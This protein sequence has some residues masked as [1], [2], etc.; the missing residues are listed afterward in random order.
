MPNAVTERKMV[1]NRPKSF[2]AKA[3]FHGPKRVL[4]TLMVIRVAVSIILY[5]QLKHCIKHLIT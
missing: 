4:F 5:L 2:N 3:S 1:E